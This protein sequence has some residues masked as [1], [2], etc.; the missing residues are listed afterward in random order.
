[1]SVTYSISFQAHNS[2]WS[3]LELLGCP[4]RIPS[5]LQSREKSE[6]H[7]CVCVELPQRLTLP[8]TFDVSVVRIIRRLVAKTFLRFVIVVVVTA[9]GDNCNRKS[10]TVQEGAVSLGIRQSQGR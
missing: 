2:P 9:A 6:S 1:M 8:R 10:R 4:P 7:R 5:G 3:Y